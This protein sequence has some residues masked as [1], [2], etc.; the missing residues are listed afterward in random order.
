[1]LFL[2]RWSKNI[3][4]FA[5]L[6]GFKFYPYFQ[7]LDRIPPF[8]LDQLGQMENSPA[9]EVLSPVS[10]FCLLLEDSIPVDQ[11]YGQRCKSC[12]VRRQPLAQEII[13]SVFFQQVHIVWHRRECVHFSD[14]LSVFFLEGCCQ[15]FRSS[16]L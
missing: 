12:L 13:E 11:C 1:M 6:A 3:L 7:H 15:R 4:Y 2:V 10:S 16:C 8:I 14:F 5:Y 9:A